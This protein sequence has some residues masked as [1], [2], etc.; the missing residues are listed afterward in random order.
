MPKACGKRE[1]NS[2]LTIM[3]QPIWGDE[4]R[5]RR[6]TKEKNRKTIEKV[7][8]KE[9]ARETTEKVKKN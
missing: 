3:H 7:K 2:Y 1:S 5:S 4:A 8:K 6:I 9:K